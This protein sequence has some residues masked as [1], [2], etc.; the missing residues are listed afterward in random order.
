MVTIKTRTMVKWEIITAAAAELDEYK[1]HQRYKA[2]Q[3]GSYF[4]E[5][6]LKILLFV[7]NAITVLRGFYS[8][9]LE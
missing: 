3:R 5:D 1:H 7:I 8:D 4:T 6:N 2:Y 9:L